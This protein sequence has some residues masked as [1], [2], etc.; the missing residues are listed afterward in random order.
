MSSTPQAALDDLAEP[1]FNIGFLKWRVFECHGVDVL[2]KYFRDYNPDL[3]DAPF[4]HLDNITF[5][6]Y[7]DKAITRLYSQPTNSISD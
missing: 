1:S 2:G 7:L 3:H 4:V 6:P 5:D